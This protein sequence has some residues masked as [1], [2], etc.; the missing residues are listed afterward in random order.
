MR[1]N[2]LPGWIY[3]YMNSV[4]TFRPIW[5]FVTAWMMPMGRENIK[6]IATAN[7]KAHQ[8]RLVG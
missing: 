3:P 5:L 2:G 7:R 4:K 6:E 1:A 8:D